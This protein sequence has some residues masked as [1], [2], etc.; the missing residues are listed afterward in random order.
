[1]INT[2]YADFE[3]HEWVIIDHGSFDTNNHPM[4]RP[5]KASFL[6]VLMQNANE[7]QGCKNQSKAQHVGGYAEKP[8]N[9]SAKCN[10]HRLT[11]SVDHEEDDTVDI[12]Y[13]EKKERDNTRLQSIGRLSYD[14]RSAKERR[15][16]IRGLL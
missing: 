1:M 14:S 16:R 12:F 10:S 13:K 3:D 11:V 9:P 5:R 15:L 6:E 2:E 4:E 7:P 8:I